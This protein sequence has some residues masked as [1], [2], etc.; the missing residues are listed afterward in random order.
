MYLEGLLD[1]MIYIIQNAG[2]GDS[3]L[4][5]FAFGSQAVDNIGC[6]FGLKLRGF[7]SSLQHNESAR[8]ALKELSIEML[9]NRAAKP[10]QRL[11][12]V[13]LTTLYAIHTKNT[14]EE[15]NKAFLDQPV[16]LQGPSGQDDLDLMREMQQA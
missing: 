13:V 5:A 6:Q 10:H 4:L 11:M 9:S 12:L 7:S 2:L 8:Q 15:T 1:A 3:A 14:M 16:N